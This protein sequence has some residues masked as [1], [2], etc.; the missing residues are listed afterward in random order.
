MRRAIRILGPWRMTA[1]LLLGVFSTVAVAWWIAIPSDKLPRCPINRL[2]KPTAYYSISTVEGLDD[3]LVIYSAWMVLPGYTKSGMYPI[4]ADAVERH[5]EQA[6][7]RLAQGGIAP[8]IR[9]RIQDRP[10]W[11][12]GVKYATSKLGDEYEDV[13]ISE[14]CFGF[15]LPC[16]AERSLDGEKIG[17]RYTLVSGRS[18]LLETGYIVIPR[19]VADALGLRPNNW[20]G[21]P[22]ETQTPASVV[23]M[24]FLLNSLC[25]GI[26]LYALMSIPPCISGLRRR[27]GNRCH[28]C[29]Y[30]LNGLTDDVCPECGLGAV[31][32]LGE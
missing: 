22:P 8:Q 24:A 20:P 3:G 17:R 7:E 32:H 25:Y 21:N 14:R 31:D 13:S 4:P 5:H 15:P 27:L 26:P 9:V 29:G 10:S 23:P 19:V 12:R 11:I 2:W 18:P 28:A 1:S 30:S 16:L 6:A